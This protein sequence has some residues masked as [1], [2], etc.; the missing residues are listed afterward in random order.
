MCNK[1]CRWF[2]PTKQVV[3][4]GFVASAR[5]PLVANALG[6]GSGWQQS[7]LD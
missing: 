6:I 1:L 5:D 3:H 2:F 4:K 7:K